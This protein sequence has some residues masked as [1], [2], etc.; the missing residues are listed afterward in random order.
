MTDEPK[1]PQEQPT[2]GSACSAVVR[3]DDIECPRCHKFSTS[4]K[5]DDGCLHCGH[6]NGRTAEAR[7]RHALLYIKDR[8]G[9][10]A[11]Q[12][13][14]DIEPALTDCMR[15]VRETLATA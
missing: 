12:D 4:P 13:D 10:W 2:A 11:I 7:Y 14:S 3:R 8:T 5:S 1:T 15:V 6:I 9:F